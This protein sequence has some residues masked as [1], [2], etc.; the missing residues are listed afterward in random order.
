MDCRPLAILNFHLPSLGP[1]SAAALTVY[2]ALT[3]FFLPTPIYDISVKLGQHDDSDDDRMVTD[4]NLVTSILS[5]VSTTPILTETNPVLF[6]YRD[7]VFN[8]G[9]SADISCHN[10]NMRQLL[11]DLQASV[12]FTL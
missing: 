5:N 1:K 10:R 12:F 6:I 3:P 11:V 4:Q 9:S 8:L 7:I 2:S